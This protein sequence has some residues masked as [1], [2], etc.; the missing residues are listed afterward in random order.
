M[1]IHNTTQIQGMRVRWV[2]YVL[3]LTVLAILFLSYSASLSKDDGIDLSGSLVPR[4]EIHYGGP[5]RDGIPSIDK[6][7]FVKA[8]QATFLRPDDHILGLVY[9]GVVRAYAIKI[10]NYHEIVNDKIGR[11]AIVVS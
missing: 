1:I 7:R 9:D 8:D 10:L 5:A 6:P 2:I 11:Q 3:A 4:D